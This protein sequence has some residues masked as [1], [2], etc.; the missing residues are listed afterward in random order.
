[1]K[2]TKLSLDYDEDEPLTLGLVRLSKPLPDYEFFYHLNRLTDYG[3]SRI[4]DLKIEKTYYRYHH[5]CFSTYDE[6]LQLKIWFIAN[7]SSESFKK[8]EITELFTEENET[9]YLLPEH[10]ETDYLIKTSEGFSDFSLILQP[11]SLLFPIQDFQ[12][13]S[14]SEFYKIILYYE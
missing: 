14:S 5:P 2:K 4:E 11:K 1:M 13:D 8:Q 3:F 9:H 7:K 6:K 12:L 10:R